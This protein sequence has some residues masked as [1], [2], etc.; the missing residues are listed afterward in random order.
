MSNSNI[1]KQRGGFG[2]ISM[3]SFYY[4]DNK[5]TDFPST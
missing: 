2:L 5:K 4:V 1:D 3:I